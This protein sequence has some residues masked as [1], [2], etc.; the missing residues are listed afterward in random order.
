MG[1]ISKCPLYFPLILHAFFVT[2]SLPKWSIEL[3]QPKMSLNN[4]WW[5]IFHNKSCPSRYQDWIY[6][7]H[8]VS[9]VKHVHIIMFKRYTSFT[10]Y[11]QPIRILN[12]CKGMIYPLDK[13]NTK[14]EYTDIALCAGM[15]I[16]A[17]FLLEGK[18]YSHTW[19]LYTTGLRRYPGPPEK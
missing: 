11:K 7:F 9:F 8:H 16:L 14:Y 4:F 2:W 17:W 5:N 12:F 6:T 1:K 15:E 18:Y 13:R 19:F 3:V 10:S